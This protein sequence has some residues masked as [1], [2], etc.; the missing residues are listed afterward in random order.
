MKEAIL[1]VIADNDEMRFN[2]GKQKMD[3]FRE[4]MAKATSLATRYAEG[5]VARH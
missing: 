1:K 5:H 2:T 4:E 3:Y